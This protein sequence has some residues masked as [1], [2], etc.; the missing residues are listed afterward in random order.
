[1]FRPLFKA[2]AVA[3]AAAILAIAVASDAD[4]RTRHRA[5]VSKSNLVTVTTHKLKKRFRVAAAYA[6]AF[7]GFVDDFEQSGGTIRFIG[8]FRSGHCWTGGLHPC[9]RAIDICQY[10][11]GVVDRRCHWPRNTTQLAHKWGLTDGATWRHG[12]RGHIEARHPGAVLAA[13]RRNEGAAAIPLPR[14]KPVVVSDRPEPPKP[15]LLDSLYLATTREDYADGLTWQPQPT[16]SVASL[17]PEPIYPT[18]RENIFKR[19]LEGR[20]IQVQPWVNL[21]CPNGKSL[22][23]R[24]QTMLADVRDFFKSSVLVNSAYRNPNYNRK[25]GGARRS[26]HMNCKATDFRVAGVSSRTVYDYV[27]DNRKRWKITGLGY[28]GPKGHIHADVRP[29]KRLVEWSAVNKK[30]RYAKH[31]HHRKQH[32]GLSFWE[33]SA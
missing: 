16:V 8:G 12:D 21:E 9:G 14:P 11:R 28:Y 29:T 5:T 19:Y 26:Q 15:T 3:I 25:V 32:A 20:E 10:S 13:I 1:M 24:L 23:E 22:P 30:K 27:R 2:T 33:V 6:P 4:A 17:K 7:K 31:H 18:D